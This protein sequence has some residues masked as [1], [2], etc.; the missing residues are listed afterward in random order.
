[1]K[2]T[3]TVSRFFVLRLVAIASALALT[4]AVRADSGNELIQVENIDYVQIRKVTRYI[5]FNEFQNSVDP[6]DGVFIKKY[7]TLDWSGSIKESGTISILGTQRTD[8]TGTASFQE[9]VLANNLLRRE[10]RNLGDPSNEGDGTG[11]LYTVVGAMGGCW[12][13]RHYNLLNEYPGSPGYT[14]HHVDSSVVV[15][16]TRRDR[17]GSMGILW[18]RVHLPCNLFTFQTPS[19]TYWSTGPVTEELSDPSE[20]EVTVDSVT[21]GHFA[22]PEASLIYRMENNEGWSPLSTTPGLIEDVAYECR[23]QFRLPDGCAGEGPYIMHVTIESWTGNGPRTTQTISQA[24]TPTSSPAGLSEIEGVLELRAEKMGESKRILTAVLEIQG[25]DCARC[26]T[27]PGAPSAWLGS[28]AWRMDLGSLPDGTTAGLVRLHAETISPSLFTP[29]ALEFFPPARRNRDQVVVRRSDQS[30]RQIRTGRH[31]LD[32]MSAEDD[33]SVPAG[34]YELRFFAQAGSMP[35]SSGEILHAPAGEPLSVTRIADPAGEGTSV[36]LHRHHADQSEPASTWVYAHDATTD[37]WTFTEGDLRRTERQVTPVSAT[38]DSE[39]TIVWDLRH[40]EVKLSDVVEKHRRYALSGRDHRVR[41]ERI[42]DPDGEALVSTWQY[43]VDAKGMLRLTASSDH[44]GGWT[45]HTYRVSQ[46]PGGMVERFYNDN[47]PFLNSGST[48]PVSEQRTRLNYTLGTADKDGDGRVERDSYVYN[49]IGSILDIS[50][51]R[52]FSKST[53]YRGMKC[54]VVH[55][56][57]YKIASV[58]PND[59]TLPWEREYHYTD[60]PFAGRVAYRLSPNGTLETFVY[61]YD[62]GSGEITEIDETGVPTAD[63]LSVAQGTRTIT[64]TD[65]DGRRLS[66]VTTDLETGLTV[67]L[68]VVLERDDSGNATLLQ[69][70]DGSSEMRAYNPCCGRLQS[71]TRYGRT[72]SYRYDRLGH[73][74]AE[75]SD[76]LRFEYDVD[77]LGRRLRTTRIGGDGTSIVVRVSGYD[78]AGRL[79]FERDA[80]DRTTLFDEEYLPDRSV[81]RTTTFPDATTAVDVTNADGSPNLRAGSRSVPAHWDHALET[82]DG[83]PYLVTTEYRG[84]RGGDVTEW[85]RVV[86]DGFGL[87]VAMEF[88]DGASET[89]TYDRMQRLVR[90]DDD[91]GVVTLFGYNARGEQDVTAI[92]V[93]RNGLIDFDGSDRIVRTR[94]TYMARNGVAVERTTAEVWETEGENETIE[95]EVVDVSVDGLKRWQTSRGLTTVSATTFDHAGGREDTVTNP[96]GSR[97]VQTYAQGRLAENRRYDGEGA[98]LATSEF[99]YDAH[100]RRDV[101][102][103]PEG[104]E[105]VYSY[106]ADDQVRSVTSPDPDSERAGPGSDPQVRTYDYDAGG[107][108]EKI[109]LPDGGEVHTTYW[110]TGQVR[111]TWGTRTYPVEYTYDNQGRPATLTTWQDFANDSGRAVTTWRYHSQRGWLEQKTYADGRG[112]V[113]GYTPA[114]RLERRTWVRDGGIVTAYAYNAAGDLSGIDYS[115]DTT[116]VAFTHDRQG[117]VRSITDDSGERYYDYHAS[118]QMASERYTSGVFT[119]RSVERTYDALHRLN[120]LSLPGTAYEVGY[121]YDAASRLHHVTTGDSR[122]TYGYLPNTSQIGSVTFA[123][124]GVMKLHVAKNYDHLQRLRSIVS[125][126]AASAPMSF[127]YDYN[128]ANQR[129]KATREN[130]A[131]WR[132]DYDALGQVTGGAKHRADGTVHPGLDFAWT[133]DDIGNR[134]TAAREAT[135]SEHRAVESYTANALNQ[136][137]SR[138]VPGD[139]RVTGEAHPLAT[140][141]VTHPAPEGPVFATDRNGDAFAWSRSIDSS[142]APHFAPLAITGVRNDAGP[143]GEDAVTEERRDVFLPQTPE[144][145]AHDADGNLVA[146]GRWTYRWNAENRLVAMETNPSAAAAGA[147]DLRLAFAYDAQGRRFDKKVSKRTDGEWTLDSHT[148]FI[149]DDWNMIAEIDARALGMSPKTYLWGLDLSGDFQGAGGVGGLLFTHVGGET[150][151]AAYDGNGNVVGL[152]NLTTGQ[153]SA[154]YEYSPF[155]ETVTAAGPAAGGNPFRFSTKFGEDESGLLYYGFRY[156]NRSSGRW[157]SRD[158]IGEN[159]GLNLYGYVFNNPI[160]WI[161]ALGLDVTVHSRDVSGTGGTGAHSW[162]EVSDTSGRNSYSG[163]K[164]ANG[165]LGVKKDYPSDFDAAKKGTETSKKLVPPPPG[166][167]QAEWDKK[168]RDSAEKQ[169]K[170]DGKRTYKL[171]GGDGGKKSGNCHTTTSDILEGAGGSVPKDWDPPGLDWGLRNE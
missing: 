161:D 18:S 77:A 97:W 123:Q 170:K 102:V 86:R 57:R 153:T 124:A 141:T 167:T 92:D 160:N 101:E 16:S 4:P 51:T 75:E 11:G 46:F 113:Y 95:V 45:T 151:A 78:L 32:I 88:P 62:S 118:G 108:V 84:P 13:E 159:G 121:G 20:G 53:T 66:R 80:L 38:E 1:M 15:S 149:Y 90:Q 134:R 42:V 158:P 128:D 39:R 137:E 143:A 155:G 24:V 65:G 60:A 30:L 152:V 31:L 55:R 142:S 48:S 72:S 150:H 73:L 17:F 171:G 156:Y 34:G 27:G 10:F 49:R 21:A 67:D 127:A 106:F 37:T 8:F 164:D 98:M 41:Y 131:E 58:S 89:K 83:L 117:R 144:T 54:S 85:R 9:G 122:A 79:R 14:M 69:H 110:P 61:Q 109:T 5:G 138:T 91:D 47:G 107:R 23:L 44:R 22:A 147:P 19:D 132:Y 111:R 81:R 33:P 63:L 133:Y 82:R 140:V 145:F 94:R 130:L 157:P 29:A 114:G 74:I 100:G 56:V 64:V 112:P 116:D 7:K 28:V 93:N 165:N 168:V 146:D 129:T 12:P 70:L 166:M 6:A 169:L 71:V 3:R 43:A 104:G 26:S 99:R 162:T 139:L 35:V 59:A 68:E 115:D 52:Q 36:A 120:T 87:E 50:L 136:Y 163:I 125:A 105:T 25:G 154:T 76:G 2:H 148:Q 135:S 96:D 103:N 119:G 40:G 126:P